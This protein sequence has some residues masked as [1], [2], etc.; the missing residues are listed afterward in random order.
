MSSTRDYTQSF[1]GGELTPEFWGHI[2]DA[3][4]QSGLATCRNFVPL[5]HGPAE[6]R[7]GFAFVLA[8][9]DSGTK[10]SRL[11]PFTYSTTQTMVLELGE[12]Y[13][14]FHTQG[15]TLLAGTPAAWL[16]GT[17][18]AIA[19]MVTSAGVRYYC[20]KA[21]TGHIPPNVTYWYPM[22]ANDVY[23]IPNPFAEADLFDIHTVQSADVLTLVH[24]NYP[25]Q[26]LRR[27]GATTWV[28]AAISFVAPLV[29]PVAVSATATVATGS[30]F[31]NY[32]YVVTA[33]GGGDTRLEQSPSSNTVSCSN[34]LLTTGNYNTV[35]WDASVGA[36]TYNVYKGVNG[37]FG[38][39]GQ[40]SG[41]T[42]D[43]QNILADLAD[44]PPIQNNPF[45]ATGDYPGAV[46]Y[47]EQRR[48]FAGTINKPQNLWMTRSGTESDM[49]Y[50]FPTLDDDS[51]VFR[52]SAREANTIRHIVPLTSLLLLTS[53]A[54]WRVTSI[55]T[56][57]ITPASVSVS[58]QSFIGA[59]NTQPVIVNNNV[60]FVASRGGHIREMAY[61]WQANGYITGD[62]SLRAPHLFNGFDLIDMCYVKAP[63]PI[64]WAVSTNGTLLSLTYVPEQQIGAW[65]HHDT[66]GT[67]ESCAA[68]AEGIEDMLYV[69]VKRHINGQDVRYVEQKQTRAYSTQAAAFFVDAGLSGTFG[70][71]VTVLSDLDHLEGQMVNILADGAVMPP[72][73]VVGGSITLEQPATAVTVGLPI[74]AD[75][76]TL[77]IAA[78][79]DAAFGQGKPKNVNKVFLRVYRSGG[80]FAG[81]D[82]AHLTEAKQRTTEPFGSPPNLIS[83]EV[84][85]VITPSW[86]TGG[87]VFI[88]QS[89]PLPLTVVSITS[90]V[91]IGG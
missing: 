67:F 75:L 24:P 17:A 13:F 2:G 20:V 66:P 81:P 57:A 47:Y 35:V 55:N 12:G 85:I 53:S 60:L 25:P 91:T 69:I 48:V 86:G 29:A 49:S 38:Y 6:N 59:N 80:I 5:P 45:N 22:P 90:N 72:Q 54:E 89:D 56:D 3:K 14:R 88:R 50:S 83:D 58:P 70:S 78:Q 87:Q 9:K 4:Y 8:T 82:A 79:V 31:I 33:S 73:I 21:H 65:A 26:E 41:V 37:L 16:I 77:P 1:S 62:L 51:I 18:Y 43:D 44:T 46:S 34:N 23:E 64:M 19:D 84:P 71:P 7:A 11:L 63:Y 10:K 42:F 40:T 52:V 27:L 39:I 61:S 36:A 74:T 28:L 76:Y 15:A 68:V 30:G 32:D